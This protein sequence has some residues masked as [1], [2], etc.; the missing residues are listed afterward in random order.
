MCFGLNLGLLWKQQDK[1]I[2]GSLYTMV[3]LETSTYRCTNSGTQVQKH[4]PELNN[5]VNN[6]GAEYLV[7]E[8]FNHPH[9]HWLA[10]QK[11]QQLG[12]A[13]CAAGKLIVTSCFNSFSFAY[14]RSRLASGH[15]CTSKPQHG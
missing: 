8:T 15:H 5:F 2:L 4:T 1:T 10:L 12:A 11:Q 13:P 14:N 9:S 3:G 6:W 7:Q